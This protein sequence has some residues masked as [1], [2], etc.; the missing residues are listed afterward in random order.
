MAQTARSA[1]V[2][3]SLC[4]LL[5]VA[6]VWGFNAAT[7]PFP[8]RTKTPTCV[9]TS[10][11]AGQKIFP[12][13]V[14]VSVYNASDRT[15]LAR[16]TMGL[17][18]DAGFHAGDTGDAPQGTEV[19]VAAIWTRE[20]D[21]PAVRLVASHLGRKVELVEREGRGAGITVVVGGRFDDLAKGL[22]KLTVK[23]DATICS[24]PV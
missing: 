21:N 10:V 6:A 24:P 4:V 19:A 2:L 3:G 15:G 8:G 7:E 11:P 13:Q 20:P 17:L 9:A 18:E 5:V 12:P 23:R 14:T 1:A 22:R 16:R